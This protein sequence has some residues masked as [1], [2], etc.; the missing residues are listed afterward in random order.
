MVIHLHGGEDCQLNDENNVPDEGQDMARVAQVI[1]RLRAET[2]T[3]AE[4]PD[5]SG[6]RQSEGN[7]YAVRERPVS[8]VVPQSARFPPLEV[9]QRQ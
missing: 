1:I 7:V 2:S 3:A 5:G 9:S 8:K 4:Q 6:G